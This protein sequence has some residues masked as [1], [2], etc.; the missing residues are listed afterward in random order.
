M[1]NKYQLSSHQKDYLRK[2]SAAIQVKL[3]EKV[4][5]RN[6]LCGNG[7]FG[8]WA[9]TLYKCVTKAKGWNQLVSKT[10][11]LG[12]AQIAR[13]SFKRV[14]TSKSM[15]WIAGIIATLDIGS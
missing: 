13:L 15:W 1:Q 2:N 8:K 7:H 4:K 14:L 11:V 5:E 12:P 6:V 10:A 3:K 9:Y